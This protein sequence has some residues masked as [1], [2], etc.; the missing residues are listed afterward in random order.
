MKLN[1]E[2]PIVFFDL[3]TTG[4]NLASDRIVELF[5]LKILPNGEKVEY[6]SLINPKIPIPQE[7][8]DIHGIDDAKVADAPTF[9]SIAH[10]L[11]K[12]LENCDLAGYNSNY[13]DIPLLKEEF[14]RVGITL[15]IDS[16]NNIDVFKIFTKMEQRSL[17][18]AVKFYCE[19]E[20]EDAHSAKADVYATYDVFCA[21]LERYDGELAD[22][23]KKLSEFTSD[24]NFVDSG[25]RFAK[26][27]NGVVVFNFGK[28]KG[29]AVEDVLRKEPMYYD[30]MMR[31]D[32]LRDTK[33]KLT[34]IKEN[35]KR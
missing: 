12:F 13:F 10:D 4:V 29:K 19:K 8:V 22:D 20:I 21:Q 35:M 17:S 26:D 32:F 2:R 15:D 25:R 9:F 30:W 34:E 6:Y 27:E 16:R 14:Y 23:I 1:L 3:E 18:A 31:S 7:V 5:M 24:G 33:Q 28:H 11:E